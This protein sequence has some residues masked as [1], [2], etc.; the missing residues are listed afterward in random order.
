M[1]TRGAYG[2]RINGR[3]KITYNHSDSYPDYLGRN[4]LNYIS[5]TPLEMMKE[6]G[7]AIILV[8]PDS[9]PSPELIEKYKSYADLG[10]SGKTYKQTYD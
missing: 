8:N 6:V 2:F 3:D 10:V 9:Q 1:S 7:H 5:G 4:I